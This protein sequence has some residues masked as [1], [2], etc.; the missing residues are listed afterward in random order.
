MEEFDYKEFEWYY[1]KEIVKN[2]DSN[3]NNLTDRLSWFIMEKCINLLPS[4]ERK[5]TVH[6]T[7]EQANAF[8]DSITNLV[9]LLPRN[10]IKD[11]NYYLPQGIG[12]TIKIK[13]EN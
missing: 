3:T 10:I 6:A 1:K 4:Q 7:K 8:H 5:F 2:P 11:S 12:L 9:N 13:D